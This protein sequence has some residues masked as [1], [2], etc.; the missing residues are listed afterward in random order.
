MF[1]SSGNEMCTYLWTEEVCHFAY[2]F[3]YCF[4]DKAVTYTRQPALFG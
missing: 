3:V 4:T 1:D 2:L